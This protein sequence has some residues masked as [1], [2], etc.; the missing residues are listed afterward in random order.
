MNVEDINI[1]P[2]SG[3][4]HLLFLSLERDASG[5]NANDTYPGAISLI[6]LKGIYISWAKG[7][8]ILAY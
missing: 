8:H 7:G 6:Q 2:S 1:N 3:D 4:E 5:G